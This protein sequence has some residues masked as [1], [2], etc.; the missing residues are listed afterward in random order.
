MGLS[1]D[2]RTA[3]IQAFAEVHERALREF[4]E[5]VARNF[6]GEVDVLSGK[7]DR[8]RER[9]EGLERAAVENAPTA[10]EGRH[11]R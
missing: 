1:S 5:H 6:R 4:A 9:V 2:E 11:G 8:L 7:L 10:I 3:L